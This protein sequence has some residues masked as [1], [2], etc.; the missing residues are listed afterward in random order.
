MGLLKVDLLQA[1][2]ITNN[3][4]S[5]EIICRIEVFFKCDNN[6]AETV[7]IA[8]KFLFLVVL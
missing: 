1:V 5:N 8:S 4:K 2:S 3:K 7:A 6:S